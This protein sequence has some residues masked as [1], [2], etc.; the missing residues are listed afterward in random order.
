MKKRANFKIKLLLLFFSLLLSLF[1]LEIFVRIFPVPGSRVEPQHFYSKN[2]NLGW[3]LTKNFKGIVKTIEFE[4]RVDINS[5]GFR[6]YEYTENKKDGIYRIVGLGDSFTFGFGV[7]FEDTYLRVLEKK[8]N[9][10][11]CGQKR[12]EIIKTGVPG[13]CLLQEFLF[14][15]E[16]G[17]HYNPDLVLIGFD[18]ND[19]I[20]SIEPFDT[21]YDGFLIKRDSLKSPLL[22]ERI[23]I[24]NNLQS[25][26]LFSKTLRIIKNK[27]FKTKEMKILSDEKVREKYKNQALSI[28]KRILKEMKE[29]CEERGID[30]FLFFIPHKSQIHPDIQKPIAYSYY[31]ENLESFLAE[32]CKREKIAYINML[33]DFKRASEQGRQLYFNI[34]GHWNSEGHRLASELIYHRLKELQTIK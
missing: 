26:Y 8:L 5:E 19:H 7:P 21:V 32:V 29:L 1:I 2:N 6:D 15:K 31:F 34:D 25:I 33:P 14:F 27:L 20:D 23:F 22:K 24:Y 28:T 12:Y 30:L 11:S 17:I 4:T 18:I 3:C 10:S 13:Y 16:K 9:Q